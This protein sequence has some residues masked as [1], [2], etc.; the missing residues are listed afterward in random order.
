M[1]GSKAALL[2][3]LTMLSGST[4]LDLFIGWGQILSGTLN[5]PSVAILAFVFRTVTGLIF[6]G[7]AGQALMAALRR[8]EVAR[9]PLLIASWM[10]LPT[11]RRGGI[12][13]YKVVPFNVYFTL[14]VGGVGIGLN[15]LGLGLGVLAI[16][17]LRRRAGLEEP[18]LEGSP[19]AA[20]APVP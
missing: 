20:E 10:I 4:A 8:Q 9:A 12:E 18:R 2:L 16:V 7:L 11:I 14:N 5:V 13:F 3:I 19:P 1:D 6:M 17:A 15:V